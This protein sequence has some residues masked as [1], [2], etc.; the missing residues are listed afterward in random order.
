MC[1][2]YLGGHFSLNEW[3][4]KNIISDT[5]AHLDYSKQQNEVR[6]PKKIPLT[7]QCRGAAKI[8]CTT[9]SEKEQ[10]LA[11]A[12]LLLPLHLNTYHI[13]TS[14]LVTVFLVVCLV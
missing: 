3:I 13:S 12:Y 6:R 1:C 2:I 9:I 10:C 4:K 7:L 5:W 8:T 14:I 11:S